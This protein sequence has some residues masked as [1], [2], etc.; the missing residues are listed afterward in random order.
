MAPGRVVINAYGPTE[1][2]V[3]A[4]MSAPL[5]VG[6]EVPIGAP[7]PTV[8]LFVLDERLQPVPEG[9]VGELYVAGRGVG[10]GGTSG[11]RI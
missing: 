4:S 1:V 5:V 2:T 9:V 7:P 3:Y 6:A 10:V 8:A 11:A